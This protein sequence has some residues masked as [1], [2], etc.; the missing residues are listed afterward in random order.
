MLVVFLL[1]MLAMNFDS[2]FTVHF[3]HAWLSL[4]SSLSLGKNKKK[5]KGGSGKK[6]KNV[7]RPYAREMAHYQGYGC[8]CAG[9]FKVG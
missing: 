1:L 3:F 2:I 8:L 5:V 6:S 9:Y 4:V 7:P